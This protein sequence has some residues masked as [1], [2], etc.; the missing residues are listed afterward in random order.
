MGG[1]PLYVTATYFLVSL[2]DRRSFKA[3]INYKMGIQLSILWIVLFVYIS[4]TTLLYAV[5][6][7]PTLVLSKWFKAI[8][9]FSLVLKDTYN[10]PKLI[11]NISVCYTITA[12]ICAILMINGIGVELYGYSF[13]EI[14]MTFL[15]T[16][17][18]KMAMVYV[19]S[20]AINLY[21][22]DKY[23]HKMTIVFLCVISMIL[24]LYVI[25]NFASRGALICIMIILAYYFIIYNNSSSV[26]KN[27]AMLIVGFFIV[28]Y[29]YDYM[30]NVD[31]F[32]R[33]VEMTEEGDYGSRD[34]LVRAAFTIFIEHSFFGVGLIKVMYDIYDLTG[35]V[36]TPHNLFLYILAAGGLVGFSI[37][38]TLIFK[39]LLFIYRYGH[40]KRLFL[41]VLLFICVLIDFAKN[42][43]AL[44]GGI[45]YAL[46]ALSINMCYLHRYQHKY[47]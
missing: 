8:L 20:F 25:A 41:P 22:L 36:K 45:N 30:T 4:I 18:N 32:S 35:H 43:G 26:F 5:Y 40:K 23:L 2:I 17:E 37:F 13:G 47:I 7:D 29:A 15:G 42:G 46:F 6:R 14:R 10:N 34:V 31:V 1:F 9:L 33:R 38:M 12:F 21:L 24:Y 27:I 39:T 11:L 3:I 19:Y 16:N 28:M 44:T